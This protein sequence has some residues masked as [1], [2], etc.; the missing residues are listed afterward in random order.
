MRLERFT[1]VVRLSPVLPNRRVSAAMEYGQND[2]MVSFRAEVHAEWES[3]G[4][5]TAN[6]LVNRR[7]ARAE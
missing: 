2:D 3:L 7:V 5:D 1:F 6:I 4:D